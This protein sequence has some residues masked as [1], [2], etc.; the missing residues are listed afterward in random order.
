[1]PPSK[2]SS[3]ALPEALDELVARALAKQPSAR[4]PSA[5]AFNDALR[6]V[7]QMNLEI[8]EGDGKTR[9]RW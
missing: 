8:D 2:A 1:M 5:R 9:R 4:F 3:L 6:T 7:S